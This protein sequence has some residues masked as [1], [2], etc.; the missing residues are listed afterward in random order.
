LD[1]GKTVSRVAQDL[2]LT[3]SSLAS[4]VRAHRGGEGELSGCD[5]V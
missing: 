4:E 3:A 2:D 1:E 5:L